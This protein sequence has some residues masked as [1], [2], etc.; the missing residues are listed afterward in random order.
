MRPCLL[1]AL[2]YHFGSKHLKH[3]WGKKTKVVAP[4]VLTAGATA[5]KWGLNLAADELRCNSQAM[6]G[7]HPIFP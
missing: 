5:P 1:E 2:G 6:L 7:K 3:I 4:P